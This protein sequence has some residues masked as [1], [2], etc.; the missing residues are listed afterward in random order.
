MCISSPKSQPLPSPPPAAPK[1]ADPAV[2]QARTDA[3]SKLQDSGLA[4]TQLNP[5]LGGQGMG[6][7]KLAGG[8]T[9]Q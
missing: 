5:D 6:A 2:A 3:Q 1:M 7:K 4:A 8:A 9:A